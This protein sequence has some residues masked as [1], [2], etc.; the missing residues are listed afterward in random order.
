MN[1]R[2]SLA[3]A[4]AAVLTIT[5]QAAPAHADVAI[6]GSG[7]SFVS[8]YIEACRPIYTADTGNNITYNATG[9]GTGRSQFQAGVVDFAASDTVYSATEKAP[10]SFVYVPLV[11]GAIAVMYNLPTVKQPL[12]LTNDTLAKIFAGQIKNWNDPAIAASNSVTTKV[13]KKDKSG[14]VMKDKKGKTIFVTRTKP[15]AL[16]NV[17]IQVYYRSDKSGTTEVFTDYLNQVVPSVFTK[18]KSGT[19]TSAFPAAIPTDGSFQG[20]S[21]SDGVSTGVK[22]KVGAITYAESSF[23][24]ERG[25][26]M[27]SLEN[28]AGKFVQP[29]SKAA[30]AFLSNFEPGKNGTIKANFKNADPAAYNLSS[31]AYGLAYSAGQA[32]DKSDAVKKFFTYLTSGKCT[33]NAERLGYAPLTG[34]ALATAKLQIA[35]I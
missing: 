34:D 13:A 8:N 21:G 14:K 9:S 6:T 23:A 5:V 12:N 28:A 3:A 24:K 29:T 27:V 18:P 32:A 16:P 35:N 30:S 31:F 19:F 15:I 7:S 2:T 33:A 26:A 4:A 10:A 20:A 17:P 11:A 1:L 25:L 22:S